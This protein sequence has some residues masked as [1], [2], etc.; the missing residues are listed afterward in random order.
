M[1]MR[2]LLLDNGEMVIPVIKEWRTRRCCVH[3]LTF[4]GK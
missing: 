3:V 4:C 2:N 1:R